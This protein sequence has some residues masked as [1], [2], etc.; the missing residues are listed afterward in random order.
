MTKPGGL[1]IC[2]GRLVWAPSAA[3]FAVVL[4]DDDYDTGERGA[5]NH[6]HNSNL[7][8]LSFMVLFIWGAFTSYV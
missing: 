2:G 8:K 1:I 4:D 6:H 7:L 3:G 5:A